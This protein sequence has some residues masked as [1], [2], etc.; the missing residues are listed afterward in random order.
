MIDA[1]T[2][3]NDDIEDMV[4]SVGMINDAMNE[5]KTKNAQAAIKDGSRKKEEIVKIIE[6][7]TQ[8]TI[9]DG[10]T[11]AKNGK[12]F[13]PP[14]DKLR[15]IESLLKGEDFSK[16]KEV[17]N[18]NLGEIEKL[19]KEYEDHTNL[20]IGELIKI[21]KSIKND[22]EKA[23]VNIGALKEEIKKSQS[24]FQEVDKKIKQSEDY[25]KLHIKMINSKPI[26]IGTISSASVF[27]G[28]GIVAGGMIGG[29]YGLNYYYLGQYNSLSTD[30]TNGK[31]SYA[32]YASRR[33]EYGQ[34][35][36]AFGYLFIAMSPTASVF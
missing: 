19:K 20:K 32:D 5:A 6:G 28:L 1:I 24:E 33:N 7:K 3:K 34:N 31:I 8:I 11:I 4:K 18:I 10:M 9:N 16:I 13:D 15:K 25:L 36:N 26:R 35:A 27:M 23:L 21:D 14:M 2:Y 29:F 30:Y 17:L 12:I 22:I